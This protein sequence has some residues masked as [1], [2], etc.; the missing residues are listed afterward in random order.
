[1]TVG[2][3]GPDSKQEY[4]DTLPLHLQKLVLKHLVFPLDFSLTTF[5]VIKDL[6]DNLQHFFFFWTNV[7]LDSRWYRKVIPYNEIHITSTS[8]KKIYKNYYKTETIKKWQ[9]QHQKV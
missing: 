4:G 5:L 2:L 9:P 8:E 7:I 1:M 6:K 3:S